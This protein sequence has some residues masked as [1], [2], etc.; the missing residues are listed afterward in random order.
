MTPFWTLFCALFYAIGF[1]DWKLSSRFVKGKMIMKC[2]LLDT[3]KT[4]LDAVA[5]LRILLS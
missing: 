1:N 5:H 3:T 2:L 4:F